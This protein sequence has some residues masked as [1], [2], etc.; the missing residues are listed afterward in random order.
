MYT[1]LL[2]AV[3]A[4]LNDIVTP[5]MECLGDRIAAEIRADEVLDRTRH[6]IRPNQCCRKT[7]AQEYGSRASS[8]ARRFGLFQT[9]HVTDSIRALI[10]SD[11][12]RVGTVRDVYGDRAERI[13][14]LHG[15]GL[16][17]IA[18]G[19]IRD[20]V[21]SYL[22]GLNPTRRSD[23]LQRTVTQLYGYLTGEIQSF[24]RVEENDIVTPELRARID[25][26]G[27]PQSP[28]HTDGP[29]PIQDL[30]GPDALALAHIH[31]ICSS[32][33]LTERI[34]TLLGPP[35][36][37]LRWSRGV[38]DIPT[39]APIRATPGT[40]YTIYGSR[41][42][43]LCRRHN[44][45]W[46]QYVT[47]GIRQMIVEGDAPPSTDTLLVLYGENAPNIARRHGLNLHQHINDDVRDLIERNSSFCGG[48]RTALAV[49]G[50]EI[51]R[52]NGLALNELVTN[53]IR[54]RVTD[55]A[56]GMEENDKRSCTTTILHAYGDHAHAIARIYGVAVNNDVVMRNSIP[57]SL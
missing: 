24:F 4:Q 46:N 47:D 28:M 32:H 42:G 55:M 49:Y 29:S 13:C 19:E 11:V 8:I 22:G 43:R 10:N 38:Q 35:P 57:E 31:G 5:S 36:I 3:Y 16:N 34:I 45:A 41:T 40:V 1:R 51:A 53:E 30:Y 56:V 50:E 37:M 18:T 2:Y 52:R 25:L 48:T 9:M 39:F 27:I 33:P 15:I 17:E 12:A 54:M 21:A 7:I 20:I 6:V 44:L 26:V 14:I 23:R